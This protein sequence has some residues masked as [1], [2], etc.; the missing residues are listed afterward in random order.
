MYVFENINSHDEWHRLCTIWGKPTRPPSTSISSLNKG[1]L[2][3]KVVC[4]YRNNSNR[5]E[6][7]L[8]LIKPPGAS[9]PVKGTFFWVQGANSIL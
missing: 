7:D 8:A 5:A 6:R 9:K 3:N 4:V 1:D 2:V